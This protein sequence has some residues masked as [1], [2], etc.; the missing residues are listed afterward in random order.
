MSWYTQKHERKHTN[1]CAL[2][3]NLIEILS[4]KFLEWIQNSVKLFVSIAAAIQSDKM[5]KRKKNYHGTSKQWNERH[6][7]GR[8]QNSRA[9]T[10]VCVHA[11]VCAS[12]V[13]QWNMERIYH[14]RKKKWETATVKKRMEVIQRHTYMQSLLCCGVFHAIHLSSDAL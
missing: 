7:S 5:A 8:L 6:F 3:G 10:C 4:Q 9:C 12:S 2:D 11:C 13:F 14:F 1:T